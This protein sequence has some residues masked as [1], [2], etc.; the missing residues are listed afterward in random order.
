MLKIFSLIFWRN[1]GRKSWLQLFVFTVSVTFLLPYL[2][3]AFEPASYTVRKTGQVSIQHLGQP[4]ALPDKLGKISRGFQGNQTLVIHI[5]DLHCHYE[6]QKNIAGII[7]HLAEAYRLRLVGEEGAFAT[8]NTSKFSTFPD[9]KVR[10]EVADFFVREGKLTGA[11]FYAGTGKHPIHLVG[12]ETPELYRQS[13]QAVK[14]FLNQET[15]GYCQDLREQLDALKPGIYPPRLRAF[16]QKRSQYRQGRLEFAA[17]SSFLASA[18]AKAGL[19]LA[20]Y[21]ALAAYLENRPRGI[22][23]RIEPDL[24][25][26]EADALDACLRRKMYASDNEQELDDLCHRLDIIEKLLS[27]SVTAE[28]LG[29]F[30]SLRSAFF[31]RHFLA[32]IELHT[33]GNECYWDAGIHQLDNHLKTVEA[34]Y[35]LAEE[36][37]LK[38]VDNLLQQMQS[39]GEQIAVMISGGFHTQEILGEL[40]RRGISY[41]SVKPSF[42]R[43]D[44]VNPYFQLLQG[45]RTPLEKLLAQNQNILALRTSCADGAYQPQQVVLT[46][47]IQNPG[48]Q[49]FA[50]WSEFTLE[51]AEVVALKSRGLANPDVLKSMRGLLQ[52]FSGNEPHIGVRLDE[53]FLAQNQALAEKSGKSLPLLIIPTLLPDAQGGQVEI[54]ASWSPAWSL[55]ADQPGVFQQQ[56]I[57]GHRYLFVNSADMPR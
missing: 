18:A 15:L 23:P 53:R 8:V 19:S 10:R 13:Q 35:Q 56:V 38:F 11:E 26:R 1:T 2:A 43:P 9:A 33:Q 29:E 20:A 17:Y 55:A 32:F 41:V 24:V 31:I 12:I 46:A 54:L 42:S 48:Q 25:F 21:P 39:T 40:E 57:N 5:Q 44:L 7:A 47:D 36:R 49:N 28:E 27:I 34:F 4:F 37:S 52:R 3:W 22:F 51:N 45:R 16:D 30:R 6:V 14:S 50:G